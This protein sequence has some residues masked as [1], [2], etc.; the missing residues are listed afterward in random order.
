MRTIQRNAPPDCLAR[1]P[2]NQQWSEFIG[3]PCHSDL[4]TGLRQEQQGLCCYC[5]H[6]IED[7]D[8]HVEHLEPRKTNEARTY[9]YTNLPLSCNGGKVEHCGHYK[10]NR[11][12]NPNYEWNAARFS[13]PHDPDTA[14]L[15]SYLFD[16][17]INPTPVDEEKALFLIGYLGLD[18]S[19]LIDR[20][21]QHARDLIDTLGEEPDPYIVTWLRKEYLQPDTNGHLKKFFSL[22]K[23]ILE[24]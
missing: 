2:K 15:F 17:S 4:H 18:C 7:S 24:P 6:Q 19:R 8:S 16:G 9:H 1:Q 10:D 20:R 14:L 21:L 23:A 3:T 5:E 13:S 22:S 11:Q 12:R